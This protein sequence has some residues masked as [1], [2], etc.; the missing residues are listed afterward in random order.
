MKKFYDILRGN[1]RD[2]ESSLEDIDQSE[3]WDSI[4]SDLGEKD[5]VITTDNKKANRWWLASLLLIIPFALLLHYQTDNVQS[6]SKDLTS[7]NADLQE[8][9]TAH[10]TPLSDTYVADSSTFKNA[11]S[12]T[13]QRQ[14]INKPAT[15]S[16]TDFT[17]A[18]NQK[19]VIIGSL[20][21][22][23]LKIDM[24]FAKSLESASKNKSLAILSQNLSTIDEK[25]K[26]IFPP[27][28]EE[29]KI[30]RELE[31]TE[32]NFPKNQV[33]SPVV[34]N[35]NETKKTEDTTELPTNKTKRELE[36]TS[37]NNITEKSSKTIDYSK[38]STTNQSQSETETSTKGQKIPT[39]A[40]NNFESA[41]DT[42]NEGVALDKSIQSSAV[43]F[44]QAEN[45][46]IITE[47]AR[48]SDLRYSLSLDL[49]LVYSI[50]QF[51]STLESLTN[52]KNNTEKGYYGYQQ[53]IHINTI[54]K[55]KWTFLTGLRN[56]RYSTQYEL[57]QSYSIFKQSNKLTGILINRENRTLLEEYYTDKSILHNS[58]IHIRH[59]NTYDFIAIP[60]Q[61]GY[62][63]RIG[64]F[65]IGARF[66]TV[67]GFRYNQQGKTMNEY[68]EY[69][70][71]DQGDNVLFPKTSISLTASP[72]LKYKLNSK[73]STSLQYEMQF[74]RNDI[75]MENS[76]TSHIYSQLLT[77][78]LEYNF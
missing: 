10:E 16:A 3:L 67:I 77:I 4:V 75:S 38:T 33:E 70:E 37:S 15:S 65:N 31:N 34:K 28:N 69:L 64:H 36:T 46:T 30:S 76:L 44:P 66:G 1:F 78:G 59:N 6:N 60:L 22:E 26:P 57:M 12:K 24:A 42:I 58:K 47:E 2:E 17:Q 40:V 54:Y 27:S 13:I 62:Q 35:Q 48:K 23:E 32:N 20:E 11:T 25:A 74:V 18:N 73:W 61:I 19:N 63:N 14:L 50:P 45:P 71:F 43:E 41:A 39:I 29:L 51:S 21:Q 52:N 5:S 68:E 55:N 56:T 8:I 53:G 9:N 7:Y 72:F 49:G